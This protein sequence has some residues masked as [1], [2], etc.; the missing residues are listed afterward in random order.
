MLPSCLVDSLV[1]Q[2]RE[3]R[4]IWWSVAPLPPTQFSRGWCLLFSATS[5]RSFLRSE[6]RVHTLFITMTETEYYTIWRTLL[7]RQWGQSCMVKQDQKYVNADTWQWN[8]GAPPRTTNNFTMQTMCNHTIRYISETTSKWELGPCCPSDD[9][10]GD[11][12]RRLSCPLLS[13]HEGIRRHVL[14][15]IKFRHRSS[16]PSLWTSSWIIDLKH[17]VYSSSIS[18]CYFQL[19]CN[20]VYV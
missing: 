13:R 10:P 12:L 15:R 6:L 5:C 2:S 8:N 4:S 18:T 14:W 9:K 1:P 7:E 19:R 16:S 17:D 3:E 20:L 11:L